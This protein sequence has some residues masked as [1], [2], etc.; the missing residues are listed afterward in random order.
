MDMCARKGERRPFARPLDRGR[1]IARCSCLVAG[2]LVAAP[3]VSA[4]PVPS[5]DVTRLVTSADLVVT[6]ELVARSPGGSRMVM[7]GNRG[8]SV[9]MVAATVSIQSV[10]KGDAG[11]PG[12]VRIRFP[13][14]TDREVSFSFVP[15]RQPRIFFL[16][17]TSDDFEPVDLHNISVVGSP[18]SRRGREP[19]QSVIDAISGVL[20]DRGSSARNRIDALIAL[21]TVPTAAAR[22]GLRLG[23]R[24]RDRTVRLEAVPLALLAGV[25]EALPSAEA[26]LL[27]PPSNVSETY[28]RNVRAGLALGMTS[29]EA[30]PSLTRLSATSSAEN[31]IA[32][33]AALGQTRSA[34]AMSPFVRAL[35][36][37][38]LDVQYLAV[39]GLARITGQEDRLIS[40]T[41]FDQSPAAQTE[42][43]IQWAAANR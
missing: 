37:P 12:E 27:S 17:R 5:L 29:E 40:R 10:L 23:L 39:V 1:G 32:A 4:G 28:L 7:V 9:N 35:N 42:Y 16:K 19:L 43:W 38:V 8:V 20:L 36:D 34:K 3:A 33:L 26:A 13:E 6:G 41:K 21:R 11:R 14:S 2:L 22:A 30:I 25:V 24:D 31:R 18:H 15:F